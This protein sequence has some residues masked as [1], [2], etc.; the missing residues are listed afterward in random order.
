M[1]CHRNGDCS[2]GHFSYSFGLNVGGTMN[3]TSCIY[4]M[5][6]RAIVVFNVYLTYGWLM[7]EKTTPLMLPK[8]TSQLHCVLVAS[9][10][11]QALILSV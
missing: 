3:I 9:I 7:I 8:N 6:I 2:I 11:F 4:P 10:A 1:S 5:L